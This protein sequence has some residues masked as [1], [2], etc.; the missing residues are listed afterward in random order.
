M[1]KIPEAERFWP[2]VDK[3]GGEDACWIWTRGKS[4]E[5]YGAF[6]VN[7]RKT[8]A[9]VW[10]Y[11]NL[12]GPVPD[13]HH[14]CHHCDNPPCVN[15]AHLFTGTPQDNTADRH[16]KGR[17]ASGDRNGL[18]VH[19]ERVARGDRNGQRLYPERTAR[20]MAVSLAKLTDAQVLV[21]RERYKRGGVSQQSLANEFG[22]WQ[23]TIS[24]IICGQ[25]WT[26]IS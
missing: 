2:K 4:K 20:G 11:K 5:G 16:A 24:S 17:D 26:H 15:P 6:S 13:G 14:V 22:V 25:T 18:R 8:R 23:T 3:S 12:V 1:R 10:A 9:H 7:S 21:I 19:P